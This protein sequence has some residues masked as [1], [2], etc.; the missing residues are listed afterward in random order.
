MLLSGVFGFLPT[1]AWKRVTFVVFC[2]H[3]RNSYTFD[4][5]APLIVNVL[6][7]LSNFMQLSRLLIVCIK[8]ST[9][10]IALKMFVLSNG[11]D[12]LILS[13]T[14]LSNSSDNVYIMLFTQRFT[15]YPIK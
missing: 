2:L 15:L 1:C 8:R 4:F 6:F 5:I 9:N 13:I 3:I 14:I 7:L 11:S 10:P 12:N